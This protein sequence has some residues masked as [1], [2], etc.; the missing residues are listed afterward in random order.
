MGSYWN[1]AEGFC[2]SVCLFVCSQDKEL[3]SQCMSP[4]TAGVTS[5]KL[6]DRAKHVYSE[7]SRVLKFKS[8]CEEKPANAVQVITVCC[9]LLVF[10][11]VGCNSLCW[12]FVA[13]F[14]TLAKV[15]CFLASVTGCISFCSSYRLHG[16]PPLEPAVCFPALDTSCPVPRS[17]YW[18]LVFQNF[19]YLS[20]WLVMWLVSWS[21]VTAN[22]CVS[23]A[24]PGWSYEWEPWK[25]Q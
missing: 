9:P 16:F 21:T 23:W 17:W 3:V 25:L 19:E 24:G 10:F 22:F 2:L 1:H 6:H 8:V 4:S 7:A 18:R 15:T 5:F 13:C 20:Y 11:N 12:A 14:F